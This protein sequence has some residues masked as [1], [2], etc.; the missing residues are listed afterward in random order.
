M[1]M[2]RPIIA[3]ALWVATTLSAAACFIPARHPGDADLAAATGDVLA[4]KASIERLRPLGPSLALPHHGFVLD[5][6]PIKVFKGAVDE[7]ISVLYHVCYLVP[8]M[9]GDIVNVIAQKAPD[10]RLIAR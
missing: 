10:G 8:G 6:R 7:H 3:V 2:R 5:L 4:V 1:S 9:A